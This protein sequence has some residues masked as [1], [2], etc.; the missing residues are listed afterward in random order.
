MISLPIFKNKPKKIYGHS[1]KLSSLEMASFIL[2]QK[3]LAYLG[4]V[5][6]I[7]DTQE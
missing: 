6:Y 2:P 5:G 4:V 3:L 7:L 1:V